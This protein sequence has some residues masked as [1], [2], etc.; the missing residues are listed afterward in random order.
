MHCDLKNVENGDNL[1]GFYLVKSVQQGM[2]SNNK[3]FWS[4][5]LGDASGQ[6]D[7]KIWSPLAE[8][9]KEITT[10]SFA[11]I[12]AK[13]QLYRDNV[14]LTIQEFRILEEDEVEALDLSNYV[15]TSPYPRQDMLDELNKI[16][17]KHITYA[18]WKK[19]VKIVM[20]DELVEPYFDTAPGAKSVHHAYLNGLLEHTLGVCKNCVSICANY[21]QLDKQVLLVAAL[22]HD[23]GKI[24]ELSGA[25]ATEYTN[26]GKLVGHISLGMQLFEKYLEKAKIEE[27]L[28]L[29]FK[30]LILSHHGE[31]EFGSPK[32][33]ATAEAF[34]LH[35][36]DN[37]DAKIA[38]IFHAL[39]LEDFEAKKENIV[40][41]PWN[42]YLNRQLCRIV[43]TPSKELSKADSDEEGK[44]ETKEEN[45]NEEK[46]EQ[47]SLI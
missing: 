20:A 27:H 38:Q 29:H 39:P 37:I 45:Q 21:P 30:H 18:S 44:E 22:F 19:F 6:L 13:A 26:K 41:S 9:F 5:K 16:I 46:F 10:G 35:Y 12:E 14:Q 34:I 42:T 4:L 36:A 43:P 3:P 33:P 8:Q 47:Y 25:L 1:K 7:C 2:A 31:L 23:V 32:T 17:K 40:W 28:A 15:A 11:S 24:Q